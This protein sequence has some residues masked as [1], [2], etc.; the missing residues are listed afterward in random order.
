MKQYHFIFT[1]E[2]EI[3]GKSNT[4]EASLFVEAEEMGEASIKADE[5]V[6]E[7]FSDKITDLSTIRFVTVRDQEEGRLSKEYKDSDRLGKYEAMWVALN[8][9]FD[10]YQDVAPNAVFTLTDIRK[11]MVDIR[12]R[13][14]DA[15]G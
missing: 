5:Y 3:F 6:K 11:I 7:N 8:G 14:E 15:A 1:Y 10:M 4:V 2:M 13:V 9:I 12:K